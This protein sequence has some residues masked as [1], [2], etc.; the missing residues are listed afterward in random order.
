MHDVFINVL[1]R[2]FVTHVNLR[3]TVSSVCQ[4]LVHDHISVQTAMDLLHLNR[5]YSARTKVKKRILKKSK[6]GNKDITVAALELVK[7]DMVFAKAKW[8]KVWRRSLPGLLEE[9]KV[10][11]RIKIWENY[12][13][14]ELHGLFR[15]PDYREY[16]GRIFYALS[17]YLKL[18]KKDYIWVL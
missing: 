6:P 13:Q 1:S 10:Q 2:L 15:T 8:A 16:C 4:C 9:L 7:I 11:D 18:R 3:L 12:Y 5:A 17:T 14:Q